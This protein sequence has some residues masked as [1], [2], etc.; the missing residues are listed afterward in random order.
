MFDL[1]PIEQVSCYELKEGLEP[2]S[3]Y[4]S[5]FHSRYRDVG[6]IPG[7]DI[8]MEQVRIQLIRAFGGPMTPL[9]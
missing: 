1:W 5:D 7:L 8:G 4:D 6:P 3:P 2:L 9:M